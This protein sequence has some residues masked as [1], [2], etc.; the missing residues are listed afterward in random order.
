LV[1]N[2]QLT[3]SSMKGARHIEVFLLIMLNL[4]ILFFARMELAL[5]PTG[6]YTSILDW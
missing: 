1:F 4:F 3:Q 2:T 5:N 6:C